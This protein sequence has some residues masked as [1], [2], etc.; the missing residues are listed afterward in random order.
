[1]NSKEDELLNL[2]EE[3][4]TVE[5]DENIVLWIDCVFRGHQINVIQGIDSEFKQVIYL[6]AGFPFLIKQNTQ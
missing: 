3:N 4:T 6:Q 5:I 1:M 2:Y